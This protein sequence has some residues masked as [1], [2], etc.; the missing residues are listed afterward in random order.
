[1]ACLEP[2]ELGHVIAEPGG[3]APECFRREYARS[4]IQPA[5]QPNDAFI[6]SQRTRQTCS[7][8]AGGEEVPT[9]DHRHFMICL[10]HNR[11]IGN[12]A[13]EQRQI[14]DHELRTM[15]RRLPGGG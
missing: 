15:E 2:D 14:I 5:P 10:K 11:W 12:R 4:L 9:Y 7:R 3:P 1:M 6:A 13:T 8:C